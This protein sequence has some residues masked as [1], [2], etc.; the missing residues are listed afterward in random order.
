MSGGRGRLPVPMTIRSIRAAALLASFAVP[1]VALAA[2]GSS[3]SNGAPADAS[4]LDG[5]ALATDAGADAPFVDDAAGRWCGA[6]AARDGY[7]RFCSDFD[8]PVRPL[9]GWTAKLEAAGGT[10]TVDTSD[11]AASRTSSPNAL[12][13]TFVLPATDP[14]ATTESGQVY[15]GLPGAGEVDCAADVKL[16][17]LPVQG[18]APALMGVRFSDGLLELVV[19]Q[20]GQLRLSNGTTA[21]PAAVSPAVGAWTR[22]RLLVAKGSCGGNPGAL[23]T[24]FAEGPAGDGGAVA[25]L[26]IASAFAGPA[27]YVGAGNEPLPLQIT[28][29]AT[30]RF[31]D[32]LCD[33]K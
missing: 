18:T 7:S 26:C 28:G 5:D 10:A 20:F 30:T 24:A 14:N 19:D 4:T 25:T 13:S 15:L 2:C 6:Q 22:L 11:T 3:T 8:N 33:Y 1:A 16:D 23:A 32:V 9:V 12:V 27:F 31:D 21:A 29:T 17:A